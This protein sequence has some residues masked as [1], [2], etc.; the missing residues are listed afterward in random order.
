MIRWFFKNKYRGPMPWAPEVV[1]DL[2]DL[3]RVRKVLALNSFHPDEP[4]WCETY[5]VE[6]VQIPMC[7]MMPPTPEQIGR[8]LEFVGNDADSPPVYV[9]CRAG[10]DRTGIVCSAFGMRNQGW[11]YEE[12]VQDAKKNGMHWWLYWWLPVLREV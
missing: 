1:R 11:T 5:G 6:F 9:H 7:P 8:A 12:A 10:V 4:A 2:R 3:Y